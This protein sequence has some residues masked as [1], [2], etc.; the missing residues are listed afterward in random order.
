[1]GWPSIAMMGEPRALLWMTP[2]TPLRGEAQERDEEGGEETR[3][4]LGDH[5]VLLPVCEWRVRGG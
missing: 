2:S 3:H 5:R 1:M 4:E